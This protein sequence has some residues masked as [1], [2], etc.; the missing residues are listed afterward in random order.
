MPSEFQNLIKTKSIGSITPSQI[1][2]AGSNIFFDVQTSQDINA[3]NNA[4]PA[5]SNIHA[6]F[7][8][9]PI[10]LSG[11]VG[12]VDGSETLLAPSSNEVR[13]VI[14]IDATNTGGGAPIVFDITLGGMIISF[15]NICAPATTVNIISDANIFASKNLPLAVS[16][17]SGTAGELTS[18]VASILVTQ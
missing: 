12:S 3:I 14:A 11:A 6:P 2:D 7:F 16:V 10:P 17:T 18:S 5:Y 9:Q 15:G 8:G 13:R 1:L 4:I